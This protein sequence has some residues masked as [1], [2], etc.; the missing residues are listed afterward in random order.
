MSDRRP[1]SRLPT[2]P[3]A[4]LPAV[5]SEL[6]TLINRLCEATA[7]QAD[8]GRLESLLA[9]PDMPEAIDVYCAT[10]ELHSSLRWRWQTGPAGW[11]PAAATG[12]PRAPVREADAMH[13]RAGW[14]V[15]RFRGLG[16][17]AA[18]AMLLQ[19]AVILV[20]VIAVILGQPRQKNPTIARE[21]TV[22]RVIAA[23]DA[24]WTPG[25]GAL[26]VGR[27]VPAGRHLRLTRGLIEIACGQ[28]TCVVEG[29]AVFSLVGPRSL[30]LD[31]GRVAVAVGEAASSRPP[32]QP[33]FVVRTPSTTV[34]DL[35]TRFG[36]AVDAWGRTEVHVF[37]GLVECDARGFLLSRSQQ[38]SAGEAAA[39]TWNGSLSPLAE[40]VPKQF[41]RALPPT[42]ALTWDAS[43]EIVVYRDPLAAAGPLAGTQSA[44]RGGAGEGRW[45]APAAGWTL[46]PSGLEAAAP[47]SAS[48]PFTP[49]A[50][51]IYRLAVDL[52]V[53]AGGN[54]WAAIGFS[55]PSQPE[56]P[57][58]ACGWMFQ[59]HSTELDPNG[60]F[61]GADQASL[62]FSSGDRK[63]GR[64]T[65]V[66][67]LD[68]RP[69]R[70][71]VTFIADGKRLDTE[72]LPPSAR[73]QSVGLACFGSA[74][75]VFSSF[76]LS[77]LQGH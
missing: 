13:G 55:G 24:V 28:T 59:R 63:Q 39:V 67:L 65:F 9:N 74:H 30:W 70:W 54:E 29:P 25:T 43:K 57:V 38:V 15:A 3:L 47:G 75:A 31:R 46:T 1:R 26:E 53:T 48:L 49:V 19:A 73:I 27:T 20:A 11:L 7:T 21:A 72:H 76:S 14:L 22:P 44:G 35:G 66:V 77:F 36:I 37:E 61:V 6:F 12:R 69:S 23:D 71:T 58:L 2:R 42:D 16:K 56:N 64:R 50:G 68:T 10:M 62:Q 18:L 51:R 52:T 32:G 8:Y 41:A 5:E 4:A 40:A 60:L 17:T 33:A 34:S 45:S